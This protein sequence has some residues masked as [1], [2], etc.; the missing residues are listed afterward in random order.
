MKPFPGLSG[1]HCRA[2]PSPPVARRACLANIE[3]SLPLAVEKEDVI[4]VDNMR[5]FLR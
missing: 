1:D 4:S 3:Q 2:K 5:L